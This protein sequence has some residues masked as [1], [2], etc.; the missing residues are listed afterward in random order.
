MWFCPPRSGPTTPPPR[1]ALPTKKRCPQPCGR[2]NSSRFRRFEGYASKRLL[3]LAVQNTLGG[4]SFYSVHQQ[5]IILGEPG[6]LFALGGAAQ[7]V[8]KFW[9]SLAQHHFVL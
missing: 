4:L 3:H 9:T 2:G 5:P 1:P 8:Y 6:Q 7:R